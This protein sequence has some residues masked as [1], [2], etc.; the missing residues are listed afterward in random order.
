MIQMK[1]KDQVPTVFEM[2]KK[3]TE[4]EKKKKKKC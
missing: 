2:N 4:D 1:I 3:E